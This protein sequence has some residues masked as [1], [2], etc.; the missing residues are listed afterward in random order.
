MVQSYRA[1]I[2]IHYFDDS[3]ATTFGFEYL[4]EDQSLPF[5][6]LVKSATRK[7]KLTALKQSLLMGHPTTEFVNL[8][9][10]NGIAISCHVTLQPLTRTYTGDRGYVESTESHVPISWALMI[11]RSASVVGNAGCFGIGFYDLNRTPDSIKNDVLKILFS[12]EAQG[13]KK[14]ARHD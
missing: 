2:M 4:E 7:E 13:K 6:F 9:R 1:Y 14:R 11:I 5:H 3:F 10:K 12:E 8:Y